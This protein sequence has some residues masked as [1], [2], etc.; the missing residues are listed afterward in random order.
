MELLLHGLVLRPRPPVSF[1]LNAQVRI[2][3][4]D[5]QKGAFLAFRGG[6]EGVEDSTNG[7]LPAISDD[8]MTIL[9]GE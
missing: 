9:L 4:D 8:L 1:H 6:M 3:R 5:P 2:L 7:S